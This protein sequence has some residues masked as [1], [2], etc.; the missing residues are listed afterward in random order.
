[1]NKT[2]EYL[3]SEA[4]E[5][6]GARVVALWDEDFARVIT[7]GLKPDR[8]RE[9]PPRGWALLADGA[10]PEHAAE[11]MR[12]TAAEL[13]AAADAMLDGRES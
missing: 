3:Y 8:R 12:R 10:T 13:L 4:R 9:R 11:E 7:I 5:Y 1:M 6:V 2:T